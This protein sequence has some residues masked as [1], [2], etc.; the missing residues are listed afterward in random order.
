M[1]YNVYNIIH[2]YL[3]YFVDICIAGWRKQYVGPTIKVQHRNKKPV[4]IHIQSVRRIVLLYCCMFLDGWKV[5]Q[6]LH[7][8]VQR[9]EFTHS[10]ES[11]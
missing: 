1:I 10:P 5:F 6:I 9:T 4:S 8:Q 3:F 7:N 2:Q 11:Y